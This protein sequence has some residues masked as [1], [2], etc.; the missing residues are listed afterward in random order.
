M[1][2]KVGRKPKQRAT[3][4]LG[5]FKETLSLQASG[6]SLLDKKISTE[7]TLGVKKL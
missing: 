1:P 5:I 7:N 2:K 3:D 6:M 4:P